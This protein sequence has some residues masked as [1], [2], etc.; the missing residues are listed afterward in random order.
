VAAD[1][2]A[3]FYAQTY[4]AA[5]RLAH[6][7]L[8]GSPAA[9]DV[10]QLAF[11]RVHDVYAEL[12]TPED[13]LRAVIVE[14]G[15]GRMDETGPVVAQCPDVGSVEVPDPLLDAVAGLPA[16]QRA[17]V[18]LHYWA[19]LPDPAVSA[20]VDRLARSARAAPIDVERDLRDA[21][22]DQARRVSLPAPEWLGPRA[23]PAR[24]SPRRPLL[25][26]SVAAVLAA[27]VV[28][29][30]PRQPLD[31]VMVAGPL[32]P[33][34]PLQLEWAP[35]PYV[36]G[37]IEPGSFRAWQ[38][39]HTQLVTYATIETLPGA[40]VLEVWCREEEY[41]EAVCLPVTEARRIARYDSLDDVGN[42]AVE[43][44]ATI[45]ALRCLGDAGVDND[46]REPLPTD[47]DLD[48]LWHRCVDAARLAATSTFESLGGRIVADRA[49]D[50]SIVE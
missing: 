27:A 43:S 35:Q 3:V 12:P 29:T 5:K 48:Q 45:T 41:R 14:I 34:D 33:V 2:F 26:G 38:A 44:S 10:V 8:N 30:W 25:I 18:V 50:P 20:A 31:G 9:E 6:L 28:V 37:P 32:S 19:R 22:A 40:N 24:R 47:V 17:A 7:L 11:T 13:H 21:F 15:S 4:P 42:R 23:V 46:P 36:V 16:R 39:A 49:D 1:E